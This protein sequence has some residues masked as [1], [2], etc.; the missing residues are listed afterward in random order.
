MMGEGRRVADRAIRAY[1]IKRDDMRVPDIVLRSVGFV[2]EI[3]GEGLA[4]E[5]VDHVGTGFVVSIPNATHPYLRTFCFVTAKHVLDD[6]T[7]GASLGVSVNKKEG[8]RRLLQL[9]GGWQRHPDATVDLAAA[10]ISDPPPEIAAFGVEDFFNPEDKGNQIGVGDEVFFPGLFLPAPGTHS[11]TPIVRHG[12]LAMLP[13]EQIQTRYGYSDVYLVE[14]RSIGG[15]SGSP[16]WVRETLE[17]RAKRDDGRDVLARCPGEMKLLGVMQT[18][19][20]VDDINR[21]DFQRDPR[22]VNLGI[23]IVVPATKVLEV[24]NL[25]EMLPRREVAEKQLLRRIAAKFGK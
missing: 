20:D 5:S 14:A 21:Y 11:N 10:Y 6:V 8:G 7:P 19:W 13:S 25:P 18:H 9:E 4:R 23:A 1:G 17:V 3:A 16:A 12:N 15:I 24:I 2:G 22:G